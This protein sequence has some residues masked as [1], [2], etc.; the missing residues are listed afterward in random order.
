MV[1]VNF[2]GNPRDE[3]A[4]DGEATETKLY[5]ERIVAGTEE[6][7]EEHKTNLNPVYNHKLFEAGV[8]GF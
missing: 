1:S 4:S 5:L 6:L 8:E 2:E 7:E 3:T